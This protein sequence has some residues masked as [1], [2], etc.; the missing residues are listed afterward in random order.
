[1]NGNITK[2]GIRADLEWMNRTGIGGFQNFDAAFLTPRIVDERLTYM[3]PE[4]KEAFLFT[5]KLADSLG[6]EMAIAGS[7]GWSESG[8]PWVKPEEGMKKYV[9]SEIRIEGGK[10]FNG[11][12]PAPPCTTG[13]FQNLPFTGGIAAMTGGEGG[14]PPEYYS[15][16]AVVAFRLAED[17]KTLLELRPKVTSSGGNFSLDALTDGDLV[18]SALLPANKPGSDS[19]IQYEFPQPETFK[20]LTIVGGGGIGGIAGS[21]SPAPGKRWLLASDDGENF[22]K[23]LEIPGGTVGQLTATFEPITAKYFRVAFENQEISLESLGA[24]AGIFGMDVSSYLNAGPAGTAISELNLSKVARINRFEEKAAFETTAGLYSFETLAATV[25]DAIKKEDVTD[26][27]GQMKEDGTIEWM[28]PEG[29]WAVIRIGYSLLGITNHPAS[30]EATGLEV[31]KLNATHVKSYFNNYL[32]QYKDA[33]GELMGE[34]GLQYIITDSYEAG[35]ANWT[36]NMTEEF[37]ARRGYEML[38]WLPVLTGYIVGSAEASE[39]FLWDFRKTISE[40]IAEYHYDLLTDLLNERGMKRYSESHEGGRAMIADGMEVKRTAAIPMSAIWTPNSLIGSSATQI[41]IRHQADIRES[42]SV[43]HIYG[44]NLVAAEA[45]TAIGN[46]WGYAPEN[47][48]P[49]ADYALA[50]GLNRFVIH[51][52]VHQPLDDKF[53]GLGLGPFGQWFTRHE[54]WAEQA[55]PWMDYLARSCYM[56]QQGKFVADVIYYYG[57]DNNITALFGEKLPEIPEGYNY[58]FVNADALIKV[59]D[60]RKGS[61]ITPGGMSYQ[62]LALDANSRHM[63]LPVLNKLLELVNA[64]AVVVGDKPLGTPSLSDDQAAFDAIAGELW[65]NEQGVN[66]V[67]KGKVYAGYG[68]A[69]VLSE[70]GIAPDFKYSKPWENTRLMFVHR[71]LGGADIYWVNNRND[72]YEELTVTFRVEGR[73]AELWNPETGEITQVSY[74]LNKGTTD[75]PLNLKPNDAVFVVF[76]N[77]TSESSRI[78]SRPSES[79]LAT[80]EGPWEVTFQEGREAPAQVTLED[81]EPWNENASPGIKYFSGTGTY[82]KT[83]NIAAEWLANDQQVWID[84]GEVK[85]L[86]EVIVNGQSLGIVWKLPF[87][88]NLTPALKEG[89]NHLEIKVTDLWVN[90]LIGDQQPGVTNPVTYTTQPFYRAT[91]PLLPSGLLGPVKL[92]GKTF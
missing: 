77:K 9:W 27:T 78:I 59:L 72:N 82:F 25:N 2:D 62:L 46:T 37:A 63:S 83:I 45:L 29:N 31:D 84:L 48:K 44:Q 17:D 3:T 16:V 11:K 71:T 76:R 67:G 24:L 66:E 38:P 92:I 7:P 41:D 90:R 70:L 81:L 18:N 33:T 39:K 30:S 43:S 53:P 26:L 73:E 91:S 4:W 36:D 60:I 79:Q 57:E 8:G 5:T 65:A 56:L 64:G 32:D 47:L 14:P 22:R 58:D 85:N 51:T 10:P 86:A 54:T 52:S 88:V 49:V 6:L 55:G 1:M 21:L 15:D 69:E 75:V 80:I 19:W 12:L 61:I 20:S 89:D 74:T 35:A 13:P 42:A 34:R 23:V 28:P 87:C 40:L 68:I 50:S